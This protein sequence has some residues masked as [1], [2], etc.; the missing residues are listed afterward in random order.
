MHPSSS[1]LFF[2]VNPGLEVDFEPSDFK[3]R[4]FKRRETNI[5]NLSSNNRRYSKKSDKVGKLGEEFVF[6]YEQKF[7][8]D[9]GFPELAKKVIW[10]RQEKTNKT[11]GWD[12]TSFDLDGNPKL[13]EVK[14]SAG[15]TISNVILT[16]N[17]FEKINEALIHD[18]YYI[19][20]V[21]DIVKNP[22]MEILKNPAKYLSEG[23]LAITVESVSMSIT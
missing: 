20:L 1:S 14:A 15:A 2:H 6:N 22:R 19:Y 12:I 3:P 17:E 8:K 9:S 18:N 11:P 21:S 13:I 4:V 7:L 23:K 10:H 16:K 5:G